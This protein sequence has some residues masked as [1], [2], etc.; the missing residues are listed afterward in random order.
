MAGR[1]EEVG[2]EDLR[3]VFDWAGEAVRHVGTTAH[4]YFVRIAKDGL[5]KWDLS[6]V[7]AE[8][9]RMEAM[10]IAL[11][12]NKAEAKWASVECLK[13]LEAA[14][15]LNIGRWALSRHAQGETEYRVSGVIDNEVRRFAIDRTFVDEEGSRWVIDY[16]TGS[17][18]GGDLEAFLAGEKERYAAQLGA[19]KKLVEEMDKGRRVRCALYY[20]ALDRLI[21]Y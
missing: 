11:G 2:R 13:T 7:R 16:K 3:P 8:R 1:M 17:H 19:Y 5:D 14:L 18:A 20:P 21:E 10:L 9:P 12:L 6:R 15:S 4:A